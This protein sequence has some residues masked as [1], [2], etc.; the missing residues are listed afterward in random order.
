MAEDGF[1]WDDV[2]APKVLESVAELVGRPQRRTVRITEAVA[3]NGPVVERCVEMIVE[4]PARVSLVPVA[5]PHADDPID[6]LTFDGDTPAPYPLAARHASTVNEALLRAASRITSIDGN[7]TV[8]DEESFSPLFDAL[9]HGDDGQRRTAALLLSDALAPRAAEPAVTDLLSLA[10]VLSRRRVLYVVTLSD[11]PTARIVYKY[12]TSQQE[13]RSP[14]LREL[15]RSAAGRLPDDLNLDLPLAVRAASYHFRLRAPDK[16]YIAYARTYLRR[17]GAATGAERRTPRWGLVDLPANSGAVRG[18]HPDSTGLCHIHVNGL[19][20]G[21]DTEPRLVLAIRFAE[22]PPGQ[23]LTATLRLIIVLLALV[24]LRAQGAS[25]SVLQG[26][27]AVSML[28]ALPAVLGV[29][30]TIRSSGSPIRGPLLARFGSITA[31]VASVITAVLLLMWIVEAQAART[32]SKNVTTV[33]PSDT[34]ALLFLA[35]EVLTATVAIAC[36]V[37]MM[38]NTTSYLTARQFSS[39]RRHDHMFPGHPATRNHSAP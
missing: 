22:E 35:C 21:T 18:N 10:H 3:V 38:R 23:L 33:Q 37:A 31:A 24:Y 11:G 12:E 26:G 17:R 25:L 1:T 39:R 19:T 14:S 32:E 8:P 13:A 15:V 20:T 29:A 27:T 2:L 36:L 34:V 7:G 5:F 30:W 16:H 4:T 28:L 9:I 6:L